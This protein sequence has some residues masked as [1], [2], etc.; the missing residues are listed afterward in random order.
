MTGIVHF[1]NLSIVRQKIITMVI[2]HG[3]L[4][5]LLNAPTSAI[6]EIIDARILHVFFS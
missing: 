3:P 6:P 4:D 1:L 2:T 5:I